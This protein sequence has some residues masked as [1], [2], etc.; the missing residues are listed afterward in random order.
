MI[1][2][3]NLSLHLLLLL[4]GGGD[5]VRC[6][7]EPV[8][9]VFSDGGGDSGS[10]GH[11]PGA[12]RPVLR[13]GGGSLRLAPGRHSVLCEGPQQRSGG[14]PVLPRPVPQVRTQQAG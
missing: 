14:R 10:V 2:F 1:M 8:E 5:S 9:G 3:S 13:A 6:G 12:A 11:L 4:S 7:S